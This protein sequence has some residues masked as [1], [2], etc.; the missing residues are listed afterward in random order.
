MQ[1]VSSAKLNLN[2]LFKT[3]LLKA[4]SNISCFDFNELVTIFLLHLGFSTSFLEAVILADGE[5]GRLSFIHIFLVELPLSCFR[6]VQK[7]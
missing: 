3:L 1:N 7:S 4:K 2:F 6:S 5:Q